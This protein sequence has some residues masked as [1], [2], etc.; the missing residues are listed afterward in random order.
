MAGA[1]VLCVDDELTVL[2]TTE[3]VLQSA[4]YEVSTATTVGDACRFLS[5]HHFDLLLLDCIPGFAW[6]LQ[7]ARR[8]DRSMPI[9]IC[10]GDGDVSLSDFRLVDVVIPK[11]ISP[12]ALL[13]DIAELVSTAGAA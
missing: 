4:G 10:T 2:R 3:L 8:T 1:A 11:P 7:T 13:R 5:S 12:P 6:V 9:A